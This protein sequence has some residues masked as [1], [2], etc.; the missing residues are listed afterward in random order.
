MQHCVDKR[1]EWGVKNVPFK[2]TTFNLGDEFTLSWGRLP[3]CPHLF[4]FL[5]LPPVV[6]SLLSCCMFICAVVLV[7][8]I[9]QGS[10]IVES[11]LDIN[12]HIRDKLTMEGWVHWTMDAMMNDGCSNGWNDGWTG[13]LVWMDAKDGWLWRWMR[14]AIDDGW[15]ARW[16]KEWW[17]E[18]GRREKT[19]GWWSDWQVEW[20]IMMMME[21]LSELG[22]WGELFTRPQYTIHPRSGIYK[23][24]PHLASKLKFRTFREI[25]IQF[26]RPLE[27]MV[28]SAF[29]Y[30]KINYKNSLRGKKTWIGA[31]FEI[32]E[33]VTASSFVTQ[34]GERVVC[35]I[36]SFVAS[37]NK[38]VQIKVR[39]RVCVCEKKSLK[40]KII[41]R[42]MRGNEI[43][44][45]SKSHISRRTDKRPAKQ[46]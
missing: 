6:Q 33:S 3:V 23:S 32:H 40:K 44:A 45:Q 41:R 9:R 30:H 25:S 26:W 43:T 12:P 1:H 31:Q 38:A 8:V 2:M 39:V 28:P 42:D 27:S 20:L 37:A 11:S 5:R 36:W 19:T 21:Q 14:G 29:S 16:L 46:K 18:C 24:M 35:N 17:I 13:C 10:S 7:L 22:G 15:T 34:T 4:F